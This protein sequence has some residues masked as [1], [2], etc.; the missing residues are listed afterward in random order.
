MNCHAVL[1][2]SWLLLG[3]LAGIRGHGRLLEPPGRSSAW[4]FNFPVP[5]NTMD[6]QL[7]CKG[8]GIGGRCG[9]CG[10]PYEG[11]YENEAGGKYARG[12]IVQNYT[13]GQR[14]RVTI[15]ITVN[16]GGYS[17]FRICPNNDVTK[18]VT[19]DC[20]DHY[21]L[22]T[23]FGETR[24]MH[25]PNGDPAGLGEKHI[26]LLLPPGLTC[27]QC[28]LQWIWT[29]DSNNNCWLNSTCCTEVGCGPQEHFY[30]CADVSVRSSVQPWAPQPTLLLNMTSQ[31]GT[32]GPACIA[33]EMA[34]NMVGQPRADE[35]CQRACSGPGSVCPVYFCADSCRRTF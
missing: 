34:R 5:H 20:M 31:V 24:Y 25:A 13:Q 3:T 28:V 8:Y 16:H 27:T 14:I 23:P 21:L 12:I 15:E 22:M 1:L 19:Q 4:R 2:L 7:N 32:S 29:G 11:P 10:D 33:S 26:D 6:H 30:G 18:R 35:L 9:V 17:E